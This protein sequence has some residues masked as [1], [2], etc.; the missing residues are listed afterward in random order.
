M[1][2]PLYAQI[3]EKAFT[4][5]V[6]ALARHLGYLTAHFRPGMT[7]RG[8]WVTAGQGDSVGFP[9]IIAIRPGRA[10]LAELKA[11]KGRVTP[12]QE[13]WLAVARSAKIEAYIWRPSDI[14]QIERILR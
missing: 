4:A 12:E 11:A 1:T 6:I 8:K 7:K 14:D 2:G 3:S 13:R 10:I 9:D 5:Q